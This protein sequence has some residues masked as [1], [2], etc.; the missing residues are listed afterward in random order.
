MPSAWSRE[1]GY[2]LLLSSDDAAATDDGRT[3]PWP[4]VEVLSAIGTTAPPRG[5]Q[6]VV[7]CRSSGTLPP[8]WSSA[9]SLWSATIFA[10]RCSGSGLDGLSFG[11]SRMF[12]V[13]PVADYDDLQTLLQ[14]GTARDMSRSRDAVLD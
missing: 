3:E 6:S 13:E 12:G 8:A 7:A 2:R 5:V 11:A 4:V 10:A 14:R 1:R 9:R